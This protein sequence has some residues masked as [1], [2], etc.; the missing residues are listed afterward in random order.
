[1]RL[2][3]FL[4][5]E[6][7]AT[8]VY[9]AL[10]SPILIGFAALGTEATL[11]LLTERKLQHIADVSAYSGAAR[12]VS[13]P[14]Q[15]AMIEAAAKTIARQSGLATTDAILV[16]RPGPGVVEVNVTREVPRYLSGVFTRDM[17]PVTIAVRA[18]AAVQA[19]SGER[20]CMLALGNFVVSGSGDLD[21]RNCGLAANSADA[22][23]FEMQGGR[24]AVTGSCLHT[25]GGVKANSNL[26]LTDCEAPMTQER[27]SADPFRDLP[28]EDLEAAL[29]GVPRRTTTSITGSIT[30]DSVLPAFGNVAASV[31]SGGLTLSGSE[32]QLA[33]GIYVVD[34]GTLKI[35]AGTRVY[36]QLGGVSFFLMNG[37]R[38]DVSGGA[39][40]DLSAYDIHD[41]NSRPDPFNGLL[42]FADRTGTSVNHAISG[43]SD[44]SMKGMIYFPNDGLTYTG[45]S[46]TT[47]PCIEVVAGTITLSGTG[48]IQLGCEELQTQRPN[49]LPVISSYDRIRLVE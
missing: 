33:S 19:E 13:A 23:S 18:V 44:S 15:S 9:F 35:N 42:F 37:A 48:S 16:A 22:A 17:S 47:K 1:M 12:S 30:H 25:V 28:I 26:V 14:G 45:S 11:W 21:V 2:L 43:N 36:N 3:R 10:V 34:G 40:L 5:S 39:D 32:V 31:Y 49:S 7:G 8:A 24:V 4:R 29:A 27:P 38:L 20:V 41:P 46:G 6:D